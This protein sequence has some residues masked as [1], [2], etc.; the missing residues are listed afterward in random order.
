MCFS[1]GY[2]GKITAMKN[3]CV[4]VFVQDKG[5]WVNVCD[6]QGEHKTCSTPSATSLQHV[7]KALFDSL[8]KVRQ[9]IE[10]ADSVVTS[11]IGFTPEQMKFGKIAPISEDRLKR[12]I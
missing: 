8:V 5:A 11:P 7:E 3:T 6:G 1:Y 2:N 4:T 10:A 12:C 9:K